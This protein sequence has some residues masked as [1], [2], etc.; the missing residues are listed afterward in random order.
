MKTENKCE[1]VKNELVYDHCKTTPN[2]NANRNY[3]LPVTF[4][5]VDK[6]SIRLTGYWSIELI[7]LICKINS[8][9][10]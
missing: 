8:I 10:P 7:L 2:S 4:T 5:N 1:L 3:T 9:D 6:L